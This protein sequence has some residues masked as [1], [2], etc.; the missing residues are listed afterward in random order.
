MGGLVGASEQLHAQDL[1]AREAFA[2]LSGFPVDRVT[3]IPN[4]SLGLV[5]MAFGLH[6]GAVLVS[7]GEFPANIYPWLCAS[8]IGRASIQYMTGGGEGIVTPDS[9]AASLT[10][11]TIAVTVSAVDFRTGYRADLAGIRAVIGP[12]RLL[13]VDGIQGFGAVDLDW[14]A[15]DVL[16]VGGQK[17]LHLSPFAT[18]SFAA[19]LELVEM[20]SIQAIEER[21]ATG[22]DNLIEQLDTVGVHVLSPRSRAHRAGIVVAAIPDGRTT[23]A[24]ASLRAAG[25]TATVHRNERIRLSAHATTPASSLATAAEILGA[26]T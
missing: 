18:G 21:I 5:Q 15:A 20:A 3:L 2:R 14:S 10:R 24:N 16:V 23:E 26:Y 11:D 8:G 6:D 13:I 12:D 22:V 9:I 25:I 19:A 4:T 17:W 7:T 1:R